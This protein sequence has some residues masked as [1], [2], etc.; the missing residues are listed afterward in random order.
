[1][2]LLPLMEVQAG[3]QF[4]GVF[5]VEHLKLNFKFNSDVPVSIALV[6]SI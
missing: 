1:V 5:H 2:D 3:Q 6:T 4:A